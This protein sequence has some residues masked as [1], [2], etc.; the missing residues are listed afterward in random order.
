MKKLLLDSCIYGEMAV[1]PELEYIQKAY[2]QNEFDFVY[3]MPLIR[4]ELRNT[5]KNKRQSNRN[6]RIFLLSL[7]D[8]FVG[9]RDL[10]VDEPELLRIAQEYYEQYRQLGGNFSIHELLYD[11]IIVACAARKEMDLV[12]S[13][14]HATMLS[15][16]SLKSYAL[17]NK[18]LKLRNPDFIDYP[19]FKSLLLKGH[20]GD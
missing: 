11:Y 14:D 5:A 6:L 8:Q 2:N 20:G 1:D 10:H 16:L 17:V 12:V 9:T 7:Y 19:K 18:N 13:N 4:K 15:D 3:G